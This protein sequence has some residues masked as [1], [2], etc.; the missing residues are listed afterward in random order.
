MKLTVGH[1]R[2]MLNDENLDDET[3]VHISYDYG[4]H[5]NTQV[6]PQADDAEIGDITYSDY[7]RMDIIK[8]EDSKVD[9]IKVKQVLI[10]N[11]Y[12]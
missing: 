4:D 3:P 1:L 9:D 5:W 7:H 2:E 10:I 12:R 8:N 11:S 6:A